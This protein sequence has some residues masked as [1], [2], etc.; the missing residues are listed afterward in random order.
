MKYVLLVSA[1]VLHLA[2]HATATT[3]SGGFFSGTG[4]ESRASS[5]YAVTDTLGQFVVDESSSTSFRVEHGF[6]HSD[7]HIASI[8]ELKQTPNNNQV[9]AYAKIVSAGN[10]D[11]L[12]E[13]YLQEQDRTNG[14]RVNVGNNTSIHVSA[15]DMVD[16]SG[17]IKGTAIARY[18]DYPVVTVRFPQVAQLGA[19]FMSNR[20][21]GGNGTDVLVSGGAGAPNTSLLVQTSGRVT[22]VD[23]ATPQKFFY[24]DDGSGLSDGSTLDGEPVMGL[25]VTITS[26]ATG[27]AITPPFVGQYV[28]VTGICIPQSV[29][30]RILAQVRP[31]NQDDIRV[32]E[33]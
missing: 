12:K 10:D 28:T 24:I 25:R 21:L 13:F 5:N 14:I 30:G 26:L 9:V 16:V 22:Y 11:L 6:W 7:I 8:A 19:F 23:T 18:I 31:R 20:W 27:N 29:T 1:M 3:L 4:A 15:G 33:E 17:V 2:T 32:I